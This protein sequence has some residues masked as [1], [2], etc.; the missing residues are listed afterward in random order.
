MDTSSELFI[1]DRF[2]EFVCKRSALCGSGVQSLPYVSSIAVDSNVETVGCGNPPWCR[3]VEGF[4][5]LERTVREKLKR[6]FERQYEFLQP[7]FVS[8]EEEENMKQG[9]I[10]KEAQ[11]VQKLLKELERMVSGCDL[12]RRAP[13]EDERRVSC[14][15]KRY[16]SLHL[17]ELTQMFRGGQILFA[18]KLKQREEKVNR[19]KLIGSPEAHRRMEQEDRITHY[20][21]KGYTQTDIKE[22]LLEDEREQRVG[23]EISEIVESIKELHT[24]FESLNSLVVDQGS[25]LDRIDVAIQQT[26]TSVADGVTM[27]KDA[28]NNSSSCT[29]M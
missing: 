5:A 26:R 28:R 27:L 16:L 7:K 6:L 14:N 17:L 18:T 29:L 22:L 23:R 21:E 2:P 24:V 12:H 1:R 25:A 8:D 3:A 4:S 11:E 10:G 15:V 9:E 20:L 19:Y 13:S